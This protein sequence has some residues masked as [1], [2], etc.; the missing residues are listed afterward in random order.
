MKTIVF[1]LSLFL[2]LVVTNRTSIAAKTE[3]LLTEKQSLDRLISVIQKDK[4]YAAWTTLE[5]LSIFVEER[6]EHYFVVTIREKHEGK[7]PG[8]PLT[9]PFVDSFR[10]HR[11]NGKI[12]RYDA[13]DGDFH[14]YK[15]A[16]K[17]KK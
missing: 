9:A 14:P 8:D 16:L 12:D 3:T 11:G 17:R 6:T 2:L 4:L 7:C 1:V 10:I 5:C 15:R 13:P